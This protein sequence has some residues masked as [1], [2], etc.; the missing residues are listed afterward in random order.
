MELDESG[1]LELV[2]TPSSGATARRQEIFTFTKDGSESGVGLGMY[3][4][5]S[6]IK[7]FAH[8]CFKYAQS[9][10]QSVYY[11]RRTRY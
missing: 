8:A 7:G 1:V 4:T 11:R 9:R 10:G 6:S 3:N 2:F 5:E